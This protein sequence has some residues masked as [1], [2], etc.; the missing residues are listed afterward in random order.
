[1]DENISKNINDLY[2]N[3]TY[4]D[5]NGIY[6]LMTIIFVIIIIFVF[7]YF[8]ILNNI[9]PIKN[10]WINERCNPKYIPFA[11][12]I[13]G[14]SG[15][16]SLQFTQDNF[17]NCVQNILQ[18]ITSYIFKP[19]Y[20]IVDI[21]TEILKGI[22]GDINKIRELLNKVRTALADVLNE[23]FKRINIFMIP[24]TQMV[25]AVKDTMS[26]TVGIVTATLYTLFG[27]YYTLKSLIGSIFELLLN[28]LGIIIGVLVVFIA[29]SFV[30]IIGFI[31]TAGAFATIPIMM[32][33]LIPIILIKVFMSDILKTSGSGIPGIPS[34]CFSK[35]TVI[36]L[37]NGEMKPITELKAGDILS[38][39][40]TVTSTLTL[41]AKGQDMYNLNGVYVTGRHR[42][43]Y[44]GFYIHVEYHP[45]AVK[46]ADFNDPFVYC[47][48]T[49]SK[50]IHLGP[51]VFL[52]WDEID[53][54]AR[55]MYTLEHN[56]FLKNE[57][58]ICGETLIKLKDGTSKQ[59]KDILID[60][61]L[62]NGERVTGLVKILASKSSNLLEYD[63]NND[64]EKL[65]ITSNIRI[66]I[67]NSYL[68]KSS[69]LNFNPNSSPAISKT[70][71]TYLYHL[72]TDKFSFTIHDC[73]YVGDYS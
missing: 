7:I 60:D 71:P 49:T 58:G 18:N 10:D 19:F 54:E 3:L 47:F 39:N 4:F 35:E 51:H 48:N 34:F 16:E 56:T 11:G 43:L 67:R 29:L 6:I 62:L 45:D 21:I 8:H 69:N 40:S 57:S 33:V 2:D 37:L 12:L 38:D 30:P 72:L 9:Q 65:I 15:K 28:I 25:I 68:G 50:K 1:M 66:N 26:K 46:V 27:A 20:Y 53:D 63:L 59:L 52:D 22:V 73:V 55:K 70:S 36:P 14:K 64:G 24:I 31:G 44:Y 5:K 23:V 32:F 17:S 13:N 42:V 61:V 41:S